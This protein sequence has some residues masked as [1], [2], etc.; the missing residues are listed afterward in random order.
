MNSEGQ[1]LVQR[2]LDSE[3][4]GSE[5]EALENWL[6]ADPEH[7]RMYVEEHLRHE[8]LREVLQAEFMEEAVQH[9]LKEP[10]PQAD[11]TRRNTLLVGGFA[12][13]AMI[14]LMISIW[15]PEAATSPIISAQVLSATGLKGRMEPI[16]WQSGEAIQLQ[17][18]DLEAGTLSLALA[19]EIFLEFQAP[20]EAEFLGDMR[21]RLYQGRV[22]AEVGSPGKGFTVV[23]DAG[24]VVDLGTRFGVEADRDGESRVAVFTG[25]VQ[26]RSTDCNRQ[27][28]TI[29]LSEGQAARFSVLAG[30]RRWDQVALAAK[31]AGIAAAD[32]DALIRT[33]RDNLGDQELHP[34]YG[35][36]QGGMREGALTYTD[37]PGPKWQANPGEP[38][39]HWLEG[40]DVVRTYHQFRNRRRYELTIT[41]NQAATVYVIHDARVPPPA[42]L[43]ETFSDTGARLRIGPW[44]PAT[45]NQPGFIVDEDGPYLP[46]AVWECQAGP[47]DLT[48]GPP[49]DSKTTF[50]IMMYGVLVKRSSS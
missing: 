21:L 45:A 14:L 9:S 25:K 30:L 18:V 23:T 4:T 46:V 32:F 37:K 44:N 1:Q 43:K 6:Q 47:G 36:V 34:F 12:L 22:N 42:W 2:S 28:K 39:P 27:Q 19:S 15:R 10:A 29:L 11:F 31:E 24:E 5:S 3:L 48:L 26:V 16:H 13:A 35:V 7:L 38:F 49:R 17:R 41:L 20:V 50:S 33:V 8:Q 40:A